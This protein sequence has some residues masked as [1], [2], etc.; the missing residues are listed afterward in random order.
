MELEID[1]IAEHFGL[2]LIS[3]NFSFMNDFSPGLHPCVY[4]IYHMS[5]R[6]FKSWQILVI[7]R[8]KPP[9]SLTNK[10]T[11]NRNLISGL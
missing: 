7:I 5:C 9:V 4:Q 11:I 1:M 2:P 8:N 6:R 10:Q 3:C